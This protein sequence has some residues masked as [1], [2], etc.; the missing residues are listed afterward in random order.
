MN[1]RVEYAVYLSIEKS[2][3]IPL[4]TIA[5]ATH[6]SACDHNLGNTVKATN[7]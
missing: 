2:V 6:Q 7:N 1:V 5:T 4:A 3:K